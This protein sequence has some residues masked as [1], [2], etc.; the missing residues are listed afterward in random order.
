MN[1]ICRNF[2][3]GD[4]MTGLFLLKKMYISSQTCRLMQFV[5]PQWLDHCHHS[6][7]TN[8]LK[9]SQNAPFDL[10]GWHLPSSILHSCL[11][12]FTFWYKTVVFSQV[13][14]IVMISISIPWVLFRVS[15]ILERRSVQVDD[16]KP[17][18]SSVSIHWD[19]YSNF[20]LRTKDGVKTP[21]WFGERFQYIYRHIP[22]P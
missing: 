17:K 22:D 14:E 6:R 9:V 21:L 12:I 3:A 4:K 7:K 13:L 5:D 8:Y 1:M 10:W 20:N 18:R 19:A 2:S 11:L 15:T 16:F